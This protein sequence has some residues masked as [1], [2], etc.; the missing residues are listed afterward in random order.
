MHDVDVGLCTCMTVWLVQSSFSC[1]IWPR[2]LSSQLLY[3]CLLSVVYALCMSCCTLAWFFYDWCMVESNLNKRSAVNRAACSHVSACAVTN[4]RRHPYIPFNDDVRSIRYL[5]VL[6]FHHYHS[7][8]D[9]FLLLPPLFLLYLYHNDG[10][11]I[12]ICATEATH[13]IFFF[14]FFFCIW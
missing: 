9:A 11:C 5:L 1:H 13:N 4:T 12:V 8:F 2:Q 6:L 7:Y 10:T 3:Q 14:F